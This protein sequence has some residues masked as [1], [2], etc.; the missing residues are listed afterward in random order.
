MSIKES[1]GPKTI[2]LLSVLL[3]F[4]FTLRASSAMKCLQDRLKKGKALPS[5]EMV[6]RVTE[7]GKSCGGDGSK[8][9]QEQ[10]QQGQEQ[11]QRLQEAVAFLLGLGGPGGKM[12]PGGVIVGVMDFS[13]PEWDPLRVGNRDLE[14][15]EPTD[16]AAMGRKIE[17]EAMMC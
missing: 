12:L 13:M 6:M 11:H 14:T 8:T 1:S 3:C 16:L 5:V 4:A 9:Q 17:R 15:E 7:G 10:I 2:I